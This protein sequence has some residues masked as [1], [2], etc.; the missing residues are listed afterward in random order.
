MIRTATFF[1]GF[2]KRQEMEM[3]MAMERHTDRNGTCM[4]ESK[5]AYVLAAS[6]GT[7]LT[8][9]RPGFAKGGGISQG[10][11]HYCATQQIARRGA[12]AVMSEADV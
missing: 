7:D 2:C 6:Y 9:Q 4:H 3:T 5:H 11:A 10:I 8:E 12:R 1:F